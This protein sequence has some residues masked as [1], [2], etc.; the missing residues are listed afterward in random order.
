MSYLASSG[1]RREVL[2]ADN[3][4]TDGSQQL[5]TSAGARVVPVSYRGY[6]AGLRKGIDAARGRYVI[7]GDSDDSYDLSNLDA[8][9][10]K[11]R[12]GFDR[13]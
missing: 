4:S 11:L 9:V 3:G 1:I 2:G 6:G 10:A 12:E 8:I 5:A 13:D 7:V